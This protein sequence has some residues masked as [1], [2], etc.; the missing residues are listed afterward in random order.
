MPACCPACDQLLLPAVPSAAAIGAGGGL[1]RGMVAMAAVTALGNLGA[2]GLFV[3][4]VVVGESFSRLFLMREPI[5]KSWFVRRMRRGRE[6]GETKV[7]DAWHDT[8][9]AK[10]KNLLQVP[11]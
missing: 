3:V 2:G 7:S 5:T 6:A 11:Q 9:N 4:V 1:W 10:N 8:K